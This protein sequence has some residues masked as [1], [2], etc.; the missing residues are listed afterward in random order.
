ML[1]RAQATFVLKYLFQF[2]FWGSFNTPYL[3]GDC[4]N[5]YFNAHCLSASYIIG[6]HREAP[7]F[8]M[9]LMLDAVL[10]VALCA[11]RTSLQRSGIWR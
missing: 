1:K 6:L 4:V 2:A 10:I 9:S 7:G 3:P 8:L 11:R 5:P